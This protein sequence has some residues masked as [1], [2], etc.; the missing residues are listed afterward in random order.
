AG[1]G[2]RRVL[3]DGREVLHCR[4]WVG[5]RRRL[6][7]DRAAP[8]VFEQVDLAGRARRGSDLSAQPAVEYSLRLAVCAVDAQHQGGRPRC[9]ARTISILLPTDAAGES[10][11]RAHLVGG[12]VRAAFLGAAQALPRAGMVLC[13]VL[14]G[15]LRAARQ[16]LLPWTRLPH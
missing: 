5:N 13:G 16:E 10:P 11:N 9:G 8:R 6:A 14:C 15:F 7:A 1:F 4:L 2:T 3:R 12:I